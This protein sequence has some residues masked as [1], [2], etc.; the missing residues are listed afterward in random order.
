MTRRPR[1]RTKFLNPGDELNHL[2]D[3]LRYLLSNGQSRSAEAAPT[4][5]RFGELLA[6][7]GLDDGSIVLQEHWAL[8]YEV[9]E[10]YPRAIRHRTR[11]AEIVER[12][13]EI[14]GPVPPID[15]AYLAEV[16]RSLARD[17]QRV[18]DEHE[19]KR[20]LGRAEQCTHAGVGD[21]R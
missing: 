21:G 12:L 19:A 7:R 2:N 9:L 13:F 20:L 18:G 14:G 4:L 5:R 6:E 15:H 8:L 11:Q 16:P 17:Y 10:D 1:K 3:V